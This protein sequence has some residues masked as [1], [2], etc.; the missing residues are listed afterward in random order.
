MKAYVMGVT[1]RDKN[2]FLQSY[3][4]LDQLDD[5]IAIVNVGGRDQFFDPGQPFCPYGQLAWKHSMVQ[6]L[7][8]VD[9]GSAMSG[10]PNVSYKD[11]RTDRLADLTMD[12]QGQAQGVVTMKFTGAPALHWRQAFLLG[13]ETSFNRDMEKSVEEMLPDS[14]DVKVSSVQNLKQYEQPL[15]VSF[16]VKGGIAS[17]T[18][19]RVIVPGDIFEFAAKPAFSHP[20]REQAVYFPYTY[21]VLDAVRVKYPS[22]FSVESVP[23]T[24]EIPLTEKGPDGKEQT[25]AIY[26]LKTESAANSVTIRRSLLMGELIFPT[27]EYNTLHTFF[28]KFESH[29]HEPTVLKVAQQAASN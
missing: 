22:T 29:D 19:K 14:M 17:S 8:Q 28:S 6:G 1:S 7:R 24:Q 25:V 16:N 15:I 23:P 4:S 26:S 20:K 27:G 18:G 10:T 9:G 11:S 12:E 13:D 2:I 3:F 21:V 5:L